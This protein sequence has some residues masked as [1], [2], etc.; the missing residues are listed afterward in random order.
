MHPI[1]SVGDFMTS[2]SQRTVARKNVKKVAQQQRRKEQL[3]TFR[4]QLALPWASRP[5]RLR[6]ASETH[7]D[8]IRSTLVGAVESRGHIPQDFSYGQSGCPSQR[9]A[10][11]GARVGDF[12]F[13]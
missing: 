2:A 6:S 4:N 5:V 10:L 7:K 3:L 12:D 8:Q 13:S 11:C 1:A 9:R